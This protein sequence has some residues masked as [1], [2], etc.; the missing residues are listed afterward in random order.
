MGEMV[1]AILGMS[2]A[3]IVLMSMALVRLARR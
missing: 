3:L 2:L 1:A